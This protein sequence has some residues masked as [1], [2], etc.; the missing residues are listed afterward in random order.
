MT[1]GLI[2]DGISGDKRVGELER[3]LGLP[4]GTVRNR[5]GRDTRSDKKVATIRREMQPRLRRRGHRR[6]RISAPVIQPELPMNTPVTT[7]EGEPGE[8]RVEQ[9][10]A[11]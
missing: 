10:V 6:D 11:Q 2:G 9:T 7:G 3:E 5:N 1:T 4:P 8:N